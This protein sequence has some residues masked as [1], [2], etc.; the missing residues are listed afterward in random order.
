M[1]DTAKKLMLK[2]ID[3]ETIMEITGLAKD[4]IENIKI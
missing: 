1:C 4:E 3:I 2:N